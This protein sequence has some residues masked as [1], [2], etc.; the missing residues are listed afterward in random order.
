MEETPAFGKT[1]S[2]LGAELSHVPQIT[3]STG[4]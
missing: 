1:V 4:C 3:G 2:N